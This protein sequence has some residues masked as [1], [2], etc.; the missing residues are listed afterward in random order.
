MTAGAPKRGCPASRK[1]IHLKGGARPWWRRSRPGGATIKNICCRRRSDTAMM[2]A[3]RIEPLMLDLERN[4]ADPAQQD[5]D[6]PINYG[7]GKFI[8]ASIINIILFLVSI[9]TSLV[10]YNRVYGHISTI[11]LLDSDTYVSIEEYF[12]GINTIFFIFI[13]SSCFIIFNW[14]KFIRYFNKS[15]NDKSDKKFLFISFKSD[16]DYDLSYRKGVLTGI[17]YTSI[18]ICIIYTFLSLRQNIPLL[19]L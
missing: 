7:R 11:K 15:A 5:N 1:P 10:G 9:S 18:F 14:K 4:K 6:L 2:R 3:G 19:R 13:A 16:S 17:I 12:F 8:V